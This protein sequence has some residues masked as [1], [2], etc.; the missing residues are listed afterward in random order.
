MLEYWKTGS[1]DTA[2]LGIWIKI[3]LTQMS[4]KMTSFENSLFH[5]SIIPGLN[6]IR[7]LQ[8]MSTLLNQ[9]YNFQDVKLFRDF[10]TWFFNLQGN[11]GTIPYLELVRKILFAKRFSAVTP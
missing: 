10:N 1:W 4:E 2:M 11:S 3:V 6:Q 9:L 7:L 8:K 5:H